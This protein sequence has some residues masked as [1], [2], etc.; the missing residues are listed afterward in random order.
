MWEVVTLGMPPYPGIMTTNLCEFL[1]AKNIMS[2]PECCPNEFYELMKMCWC[3]DPDQRPTFQT[4]V[5][6]IEYMIRCKT[7]V[8]L[9]PNLPRETRSF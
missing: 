2:Q 1:K 7:K 3:Y 4:L 6:R 8:N 9:I 5:E